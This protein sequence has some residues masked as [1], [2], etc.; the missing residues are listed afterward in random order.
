MSTLKHTSSETSIGPY[1]ISFHSSDGKTFSQIFI[2]LDQLIIANCIYFRQSNIPGHYMIKR[3]STATWNIIILLSQESLR[4]SLFLLWCKCISEFFIIRT[5]FES[6]WSQEKSLL[7]LIMCNKLYL[8]LWTINNNICQTNLNTSL[9]RLE[10]LL[11]RI[12]VFY[13]V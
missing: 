7:Y 6:W 13:N 1:K 10:T 2:F 8:A 11:L 9:T 5:P 12:D 3:F 4:S